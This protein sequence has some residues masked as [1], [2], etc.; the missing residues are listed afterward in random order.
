MRRVSRNGRGSA[1][2]IPS[3]V[4][5][6][7]GTDRPLRRPTLATH[8]LLAVNFC[9]YAVT[10]GL[11]RVNP[12][13]AER[14]V[15]GL[16]LDPHGLTWWGFLTYAFVHA[17]FWHVAGNMLFLWVFGPN[18]EDRLGRIGFL[19]FYLLAG[20]A[21]GGTHV[22]FDANPVVG[23]SGAVAGITGAYLVL[24]PHTVIRCLFF[25]S[26]GIVAVPA[27]WF[28]G[29]AIAFN[30]LMQGTGR[31]AN[32]AVMAHLGGYAFG[33]AVSM[34]LLATRVLSREP[35]DLFTITRQAARRRQF[36]EV[37]YQQARA[38]AE[39]R[40]LEAPGRRGEVP[41]AAMHARAEVTRLLTA[42][43]HPAAA[44]GY[45]ALLEAHSRE[46]AAALLP[47]R[48][49]YDIANYLFSA[50]DYSTAATAYELFLRGYPKDHEIPGVR[51][52]LGLINARYLN[53][54]V[55]AKQEISAA[56]PGLPE[57]EHRNLAAELLEE[58]G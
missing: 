58:L 26:A 27:W 37:R 2:S 41:E 22:L 49:L 15:S 18:V 25:F 43:D 45:R 24:F 34:A 21:A 47:R 35:Y 42:G 6:P 39:G 1:C 29:G 36:R 10:E 55:R 56:M 31:T 30:L 33:A 32:I 53:D 54:P 14:L 28:I 7:L 9:M 5:L 52:M 17:G 57:G 12:E 4:L 40:N 51:L 11:S 44:A 38:V 16:H 8:F 46:S 19:A 50:G 23:A 3:G 48:S 13:R 20:A